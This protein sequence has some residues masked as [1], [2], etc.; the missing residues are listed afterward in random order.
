MQTAYIRAN[1]I[2]LYMML[3][4]VAI[5]V[6]TQLTSLKL[7]PPPL[8]KLHVLE[9]AQL[10]GFA[11]KDGREHALLS[12]DYNFDFTDVFDWNTKQVYLFVQADYKTPSTIRNSLI[13][14]DYVIH[15]GQGLT[16]QNVLCEYPLEDLERGL[17]NTTVSLSLG[18]DV[19]PFIGNVGKYSHLQTIGDFVLDMPGQYVPLKRT[20]QFMG[21]QVG[22]R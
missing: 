7:S 5:T 12:I 16:G 4:V 1:K 17:R 6:V 15:R 3:H 11:V 2:W 19:M 20:R 13:L 14:F 10:E 21:P 22:M 8:P 9:V 18:W